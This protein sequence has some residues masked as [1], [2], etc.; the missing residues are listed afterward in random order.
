MRDFI[1]I[2]NNA[3]LDSKGD[4]Q[5]LDRARQILHDMSPLA[6]YRL[7][8]RLAGKAKEAGEPYVRGEAR[9]AKAVEYIAT[10][11]GDFPT[12][13]KPGRDLSDGDIHRII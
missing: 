2:I 12:G 10:H 13:A 5:S 4:A 6:R 8:D 7:L 11:L 3:S 9:Y 1:D